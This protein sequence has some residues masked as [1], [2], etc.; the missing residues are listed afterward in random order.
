VGFFLK[1]PLL[2]GRHILMLLR[3]GDPLKFNS[4]GGGIVEQFTSTETLSLTSLK[5]V[6][7][8][9][10]VKVQSVLLAIYGGAIR[11]YLENTGKTIPKFIVMPLPQ[12]SAGRPKDLV[13]NHFFTICVP[14][15]ILPDKPI[16]ER[17]RNVETSIREIYSTKMYL[18]HRYV[19]VTLFSVLPSKFAKR[20]IDSNT[21]RSLLSPLVF[22]DGLCYQTRTVTPMF[23]I[24]ER[25]LPV[26][27]KLMLNSSKCTFHALVKAL[28][29]ISVSYVEQSTV[30]V[31]S[32]A[33]E[34]TEI[35]K[36][37]L[38]SNLSSNYQPASTA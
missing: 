36:S 27:G 19:F 22:P 15:P 4:S 3:A 12:L 18:L 26:I 13:G 8:K 28:I 25:T 32:Y 9:H 20:L 23:A 34:I 31:S 10:K 38:I 17:I 16:L 37:G 14:V 11:R 24:C 30:C 33:G 6:S 1:L 29:L 7:K 2:L 21:T 5:Q 35:H